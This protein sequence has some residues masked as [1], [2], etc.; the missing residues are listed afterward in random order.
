[1]KHRRLLYLLVDDL[2]TQIQRRHP[3]IP[4]REAVRQA[5]AEL[6]LL[7]PYAERSHLRALA[8]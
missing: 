4:R 5:V 7:L 2:A 6:E 3:E 8:G 1:M